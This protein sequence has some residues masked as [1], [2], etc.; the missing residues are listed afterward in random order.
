MNKFE[1]IFVIFALGY[2]VI[3]G[4]FFFNI[5][6]M[7]NEISFQQI[8][9]F[10]LFGMALNLGVLISVIRDIYKR[11]FASPNSKTTWTILILLFWPSIFIYLPKYAFKPRDEI[12]TERNLKK[13]IIGFIVIILA[14]FGFM[15]FSMFNMFH[16]PSND[17]QML[18]VSGEIERI[19]KLLEEKPDMASIVRKRDSWSPL[20]GA[21]FNN[22]P[23]TVRILAN[24]GADVNLATCNGDTAL[25]GA[26]EDGYTEVV[27]VLLEAG[28]DP[29]LT[30]TK[31]KIALDI[32]KWHQHDE[33]IK[34][35]EN[36]Q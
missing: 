24:Y 18:A 29:N 13:Y 12:V 8:L 16:I 21:A 34:L 27:R 9:P 20:H 22:H 6:F 15:A 26:T 30:N 23:E 7:G 25:H 11:K 28:A 36:K 14:F 2:T 4:V 19:T 10:H 3:Y 31:G 17:I 35:L 33:I 1:K 32:A 5:D